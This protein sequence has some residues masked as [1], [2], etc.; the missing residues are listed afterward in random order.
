MSTKEMSVSTRVSPQLHT[1][2]LYSNLISSDEDEILELVEYA[3]SKGKRHREAERDERKNV[4]RSRSRSRSKS[5][6]PPPAIPEQ[7][8]QHAREAIRSV[9]C[10]RIQFFSSKPNIGKLWVPFLAQRHHL[11]RSSTILSIT[12]I[13]TLR[14]PQ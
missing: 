13:W 14:S 12:L 11:W 2:I 6:T 4:K 9:P 10:L 8:R 3:T 7:A 1:H 5:I